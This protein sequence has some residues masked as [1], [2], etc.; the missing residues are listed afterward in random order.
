MNELPKEHRDMLNQAYAKALE[1][2]LEYMAQQQQ[3]KQTTIVQDCQPE[4]PR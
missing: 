4:N 3:A 1:R 2:H